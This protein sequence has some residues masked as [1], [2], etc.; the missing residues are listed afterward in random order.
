MAYYSTATTTTI[1]VMVKHEFL[2]FPYLIAQYSAM[3]AQAMIGY[4]I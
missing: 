4:G 3:T 1:G 2:S